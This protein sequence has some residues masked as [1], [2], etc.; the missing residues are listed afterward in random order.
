VLKR[1]GL[2]HLTADGDVG[3]SS[4]LRRRLLK[5]ATTRYD[6]P[7]AD[8]VQI[9]GPGARRRL[10]LAGP[11]PPLVR[12]P[13]PGITLTSHAPRFGSWDWCSPSVRGGMTGPSSAATSASWC[14][15]AALTAVPVFW[16][17][18][19]TAQAR[20]LNLAL[21]RISGSIAVALAAA[22]LLQAASFGSFSLDV[23]EET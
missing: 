12:W 23:A 16:L 4:T 14:P 9:C 15:Q 2:L 19:R 1:S 5:L 13:S 17:D 6:G 11:R 18:I 8:P 3:V 10:S 20:L 7:T 21:N 22:R